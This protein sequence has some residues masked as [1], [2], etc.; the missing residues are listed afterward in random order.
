MWKSDGVMFSI[1]LD[2]AVTHP[3][4]VLV[5]RGKAAD[6]DCPQV[7][8]GLP[9]DRPFGQNPARP[10]AGCDAKGV[11]PGPHI[12]VGAGVG[13]AK[14]KVAVGG[15]TFGSVD[16]LFDADSGQRRNPGDGL[17]HV[18]FKMVVVIVEQRKLPVIR[19][20]AAGLRQIPGLR[21][22]FIAAHHQPADL[23]FEIGA[24]VGVAQGGCI[25]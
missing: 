1:S 5:H 7:Q 19:H 18:L 21:V 16:H 8:R 22:G 20:I 10:A 9:G 3:R 23:F 4:A 17:I 15:K 11:E 24:P 14:D 13:P 6:I 12:H 2:R 25:G